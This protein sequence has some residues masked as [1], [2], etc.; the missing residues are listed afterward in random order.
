[1]SA[2]RDVIV[3]F[4]TYGKFGVIRK[5]DSRSMVCKTYIFNNSNFLSCKNWKQNWNIFNTALTLLLWVKVL[6]LPENAD[7]LQK[8]TDISKIKRTL[9]LKGIFSIFLTS[10][11]QGVILLPTPA[12]Y[13]PL[14]PLKTNL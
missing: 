9:V 3:I 7:F 5:P 6:F 1:M 11:R 8:N 12:P 4:Q 2:N 14:L 13:L 10:F